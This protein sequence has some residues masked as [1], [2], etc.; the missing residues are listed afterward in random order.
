MA[1][2]PEH[3]RPLLLQIMTCLQSRTKKQ[4]SKNKISCSQENTVDHCLYYWYS[5]HFF[6]TGLLAMPTLSLEKLRQKLRPGSIKMQQNMFSPCWLSES[7]L[8]HS[9]PYVGEEPTLLALQKGCKGC[10]GN[11]A[12]LNASAKATCTY[13]Q[14]HS[15]CST[16][17]YIDSQNNM[18]DNRRQKYIRAVI[19]CTQT[20]GIHNTCGMP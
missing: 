5:N 19:Q 15:Q 7:D 20:C 18:M 4:S 8:K 17:T 12:S 6:L 14:A 9:F 16:C 13:T 2:W 3:P 1:I 10:A 11:L